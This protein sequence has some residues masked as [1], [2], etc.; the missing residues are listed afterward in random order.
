MPD[1]YAFIVDRGGRDFDPHV[2]DIFRTSVAPYPPGTCVVLSDGC[3]GIVQDVRQDF[4]T[5]PTVRV[6]MDARGA[7][8]AAHVIDLSK[9]PGSS[10]V[11]VHR[12]SLVERGGG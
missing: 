12:G 5:R 2:V 9:M 8:V 1:A 6:I 4:V 3:V 10:I 11:S 7:G